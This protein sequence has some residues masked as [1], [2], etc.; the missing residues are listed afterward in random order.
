MGCSS[1]GTGKPNGC[2]SNGG[3]STGGCNRMNVH[4][5]LSNI[6]FA[7]TEN[8][9]KVVEVLFNKGSRKDFFRNNT[10]QHFEKG[11]LVTVEGVSG[12]D[13]GEISLT[14]EVVRLQ[15]KKKG[16]DELNPEMKKVLR[17]AGERDLEQLKQ[18][19]SRE[20]EALIRTRA[21]TRQLNLEMKMSEVEIQADGRKATFFYIADDRVDFRELIKILASE[22]KLKVEMRQIGARQEAAKVGGVG[23]CGRELCCSTWLTDF[24]SVNTTAARYQNLSINQ[25]KL[26]GQCGRLKCCLNYEL[27]T[28][29]DAL[30]QFPNNAET[31]Q[32]ARGTA[33]LIKKDIFKNLMWYV[34]PESN[35]QYPVT[36]ERV[37]KIRTL[38]L[39]GVIPDEL[40]VVDVTTNKPKEIEPEFVDVV[41]QISLRT[42]DKK[43]RQKKQQGPQQRGGRDQQRG[44]QQP[45]QRPQQNGQGQQSDRGPRPSQP[46]AGQKPQQGGPQ[47]SQQSGPTR[48]NQR[49]QQ[50]QQR[51]GPQQGGPQQRPPQPGGQQK[52]PQPGAPNNDSKS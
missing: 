12:F 17:R 16:L 45:G 19:K 41:G 47:R 44:G 37:R 7:D 30:Q 9:C 4:D 52:P 35:K 13:V 5:W 39:Q 42:L 40:E 24:K 28:Y 8:A 31:I 1:C 21:I 18:N 23:S 43:E 20:Q 14:G 10:L 49:P 51:R 2:K 27:D 15:L 36:I 50:P 34:L 33:T 22:F 46:G 11:D 26:S 29:L 48:P 6:P 32:V 25:T 38:N 3:C